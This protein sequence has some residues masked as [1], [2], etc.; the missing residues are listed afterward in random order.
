LRRVYEVG[1]WRCVSGA[2]LT[3]AA[4]LL[5]SLFVYRTVQFLVIYALI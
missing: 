3:L 4:M 1:W 5:G 2:T